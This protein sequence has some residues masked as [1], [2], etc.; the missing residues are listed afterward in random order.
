[1]EP[2]LL[3][4]LILSF[5]ITFLAMPFWIRKAK[6]IGLVW[7]DMNKYN[8]K[9]KI[10]GSGGIIVI[11][12][13]VLGVLVYIAIKTFVLKTDTT[14]IEIFALLT[15]VLISAIIALTDDIFGW[16]HGGLSAKL[17][18]FLIFVAAIPLMVI[19]AGYSQISLPFFN[20]INIGLFYPIIF[21]PLGIIGAATTFN[22][23]AGYNGLEA[24]QG[25]LILGSLSL[26]AFL[27]GNPW[28]SLIGLC[29]VFS[30]A[31]FL[32]FNRVPSKVFPGDILTYS[33]GALIAIMAIL[34]NFERIAI[35]FFIPYIA[36]TILKTRGKLK[37]QS[38]GKPNQDN[39]LDL[40]Y[41]KIYGLEH[42]A[43]WFLKK[44]KKDKKATE[45]EVVYLLWGIQVIIIIL[46]FIIFKRHI[47]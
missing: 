35:F 5:F 3:I 20:T 46:G 26:V 45:K 24:G 32:V 31:A 17:R 7:E 41:K 36:E 19:N 6:Q 38:F 34:G 16:Q 42:L 21:I 9:K 39:T 2:L 1:M 22:F 15:T 4:P 44:V 29:M 13:F 23:L 11:M 47:F 28:L 10:A 14:T 27:T 40:P 25:I 18:V 8:S 12:S 30:L 43:I 37:K 33:V